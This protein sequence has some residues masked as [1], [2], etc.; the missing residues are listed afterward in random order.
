MKLKLISIFITIILYFV[1]STL[2]VSAQNI[3]VRFDFSASNHSDTQIQEQN[4]DTASGTNARV[5]AGDD[6]GSGSTRSFSNIS[7]IRTS[8][9]SGKTCVGLNISVFV[10]KATGSGGSFLENLR[11]YKVLTAWDEATVTWNSFNTG[12][13]NNTNF[14]PVDLV[15][16]YFPSSPSLNDRA[17]ISIDLL[18]CQDILDGAVNMEK[19]IFII[20]DISESLAPSSD[21]AAWSSTDDGDAA[22]RFQVYLSY[23]TADTTL[24][25]SKTPSINN[26]AP[27]L[28][29]VVGIGFEFTDDTSLSQIIIEGNLSSPTFE[30]LNF[31]SIN[32]TATTTFNFTPDPNI[33]ASK[34]G[35]FG[36]KATA[37]DTSGNVVQSSIVTF[38][39]LDITPPIA[40]STFNIS[41]TNIKINDILN[42]TANVTDETSLNFCR[43]INNQTGINAI[44]DVEITGVTAQCSTKITITAPRDTIINFSVVVNDTANNL[45]TN[46]TVIIVANT[47]PNA[48]NIV[49]VSDRH[50][51]TNVTFNITPAFDAD[52]DVLTYFWFRNTSAEPSPILVIS[53]VDQFNYTTNES[54]DGSYNL[55]VNVSD[56]IVNITGALF[57]WTLDTDSPTLHS[58]FN[59]TNNTITNENL[60]ILFPLTDNILPY[61]LSVRVWKGGTT[62]HLNSSATVTGL[63]INI[64]LHI[65]LTENGNYTI[66]INGSDAISGSPKMDLE[67]DKKLETEYVFNDSTRDKSFRMLLRFEDKNE[68]E[69]NN[70]SGL[71]T[72]AIFNTK[73]T[74]INFG[75]NFTSNKNG[76]IPVYEVNTEGVSI[77]I[78]NSSIKGHLVWFPYG[79]DFDGKLLV[80]GI[81][82]EYSVTVKRLTSERVKVKIVPDIDIAN[83]DIVEF[84]S[85]SIFGLNI[86]ERVY[87][88]AIDT[89]API[90]TAALNRTVIGNISKIFEND[91]VNIS[92]FIGDIY[93]TAL[94][95]SHNASSGI[96]INHSMTIGGNTTYSLII[97]SN[98][99][100][101]GET[102]GW[103]YDA[104]DTAGNHLDPIHVFSVSFASTPAGNVNPGGSTPVVKFV[105]LVLNV[106]IE[107]E[108]EGEISA[109]QRF[110]DTI[111]EFFNFGGQSNEVVPNNP[112]QQSSQPFSLNPTIATN[113]DIPPGIIMAVYAFI[114]IFVI[115]LAGYFL[116]VVMG[117]FR[118]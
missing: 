108:E 94:N 93:L 3:D 100:T 79:T 115:A 46:S 23:T 21:L 68:N 18:Y 104:Y 54:S 27:S 15:V 90:D 32:F 45:V 74:H 67:T 78:I 42:H 38:T 52:G 25:T 35:T 65:N 118:V 28:N 72:Y 6:S 10:A 7:G 55:F 106:T 76:L 84:K 101:A 70:P 33:T 77:D 95:I 48:S 51:N 22:K 24:P 86:L 91:D 34:V 75:V 12:G 112:A 40:N 113:F 44:I 56:G 81:E 117:F 114:I 88:L 36:F 50:Y 87:N 11:I 5:A 116:F 85:K 2:I 17:N 99:L 9:T 14:G 71:T 30:F 63:F 66:E 49:N 58:T 16:E 59:L 98:N 8:E 20:N 64:T 61:N 110:W 89:I 29:D 39:V 41:L 83:G 80:N 37:N 97:N 102:I 47:E 82:R 103:K 69:V 26:T 1:I 57:N 13:A 105:P 53:G 43:F 19:G 62:Y 96:W 111:K 109:F 31:T 107:E 60:T 73:G 4:P 92:V